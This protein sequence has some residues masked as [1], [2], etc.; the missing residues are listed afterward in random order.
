M[1]FGQA[2]AKGAKPDRGTAEEWIYH[3][4]DDVTLAND[5]THKDAAKSSGMHLFAGMSALSLAALTMI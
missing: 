4:Y 1:S 3:T 2:G 5:L